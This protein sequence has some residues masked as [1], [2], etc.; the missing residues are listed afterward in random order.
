MQAFLYIT[1]RNLTHN[2]QRNTRT[3]QAL[4]E[5]MNEPGKPPGPDETLNL[6][7]LGQQLRQWID[8]LPDRRREA[9]ELSRF[10]GLTHHEI[11]CVM[12]LS[13]HTVDKH[14]THALKQLRQRLG[15]LD[16]DLLRT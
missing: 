11:A 16:P 13:T 9:F 15:A 14:I 7:L 10:C 6:H 5:S 3:R 1:V 2:H 12:G 8:E 4:L